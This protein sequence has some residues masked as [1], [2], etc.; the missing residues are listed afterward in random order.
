MLAALLAD[1]FRLMVHHETRSTPGYALVMA[2]A[3]QRPGPGLRPSPPQIDCE[4]LRLAHQ[5]PKRPTAPPP[6]GQGPPCLTLF[7]PGRIVFGTTPVEGLVTFLMN[8]MN[9]T[10]VDRTA[11]AADRSAP[12]G[13]SAP[14]T[15]PS[16]VTALQEQLGLRL[17]AATV[18]TDTLVIDSIS[19]PMPDWR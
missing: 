10:V 7:Y 2:R 15:A 4:A 5:L 19:Q 14:P 17:T 8:Q 13:S 11:F 12:S 1:R 16:L 3:D 18:P 9:R 6:P